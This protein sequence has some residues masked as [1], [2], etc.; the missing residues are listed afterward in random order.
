MLDWN[1]DNSW[2][3]FLDR[4]GVI[5]ERKMGGYIQN[6]E[7]FQFLQHAAESIAYFSTIFQHVFVVTNQQGIGK[8]IMTRRN[9]SQIHAYMCEVVEKKGGKITKCYFAPEL[10]S[11]NSQLRKPNPG[12]ALQAKAEYPA[13]DFKKSIMVGDTDS[14]ILFGTNL[15]MKTVR[16]KT[17]EIIGIKSDLEVFSLEELS[18]LLQK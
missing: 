14:D 15:G 6:V 4:D 8:K 12:M 13:V 10:K 17:Q 2:T 5:N 3:L 11:E 7:E 16:I 1:I 18:Q 9:L